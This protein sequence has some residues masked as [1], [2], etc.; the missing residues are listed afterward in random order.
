MATNGLGLPLAVEPTGG[1]VSDKG[2]ELI[3]DGER[4]MPKVLIAD[5]GCDADRIRGDVGAAGGSGAIPGRQ[6]RTNP[7]PIDRFAYRLRNRIE[8]TFGRMKN[9]RHMAT[10]YDQTAASYLGFV[11]LTAIRLWVRHFVSSGQDDRTKIREEWTW[12]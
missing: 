3:F 12:K 4:P 10:R 2:F 6:N 8:R 1:E 7:V 11:Q 9:A 5:R